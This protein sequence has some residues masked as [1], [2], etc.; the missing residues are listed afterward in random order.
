VRQEQGVLILTVIDRPA[1][2]QRA[3]PCQVVEI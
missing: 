2:H 1:G 3:Y